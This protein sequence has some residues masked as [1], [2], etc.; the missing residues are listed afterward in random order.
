[1]QTFYPA[2]TFGKFQRVLYFRPHV[3]EELSSEFQ[4]GTD[5]LGS[6]MLPAIRSSSALRLGQRAESVGFLRNP[7][8]HPARIFRPL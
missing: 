4:P 1:V 2:E 5:N 7:H 6:G 8:R 3:S